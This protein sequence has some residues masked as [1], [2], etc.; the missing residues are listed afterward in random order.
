MNDPSNALGV[1]FASHADRDGRVRTESAF[2]G[3]LSSLL[4][5]GVVDPDGM[6]DADAL[7]EVWARSRGA[8]GI[9]YEEALEND[10]AQQA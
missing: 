8:D 7:R 3:F 6:R 9:S 10:T 5:H 4:E 1:L 2:R